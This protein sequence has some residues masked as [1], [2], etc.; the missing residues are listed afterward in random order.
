MNVNP[1]FRT[2]T[3]NVKSNP[4]MSQAK[5]RHDVQR[6]AHAAGLI[7]WQE[8]GPDRYREA[9]RNLGPEWGHY[10]PDDGGLQLLHPAVQLFGVA[11]QIRLERHVQWKRGVEPGQLAIGLPGVILPGVIEPLFAQDY[12]GPSDHC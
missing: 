10:M 1:R 3:I 7:G 8:I 9:I 12:L 5:V 11:E 4:E 6:A 2:A